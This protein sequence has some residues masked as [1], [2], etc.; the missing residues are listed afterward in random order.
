MLLTNSQ[1]LLGHSFRSIVISIKRTR[2]AKEPVPEK[3]TKWTETAADRKK[4]F[5][6][7][8]GQAFVRIGGS[9]LSHKEQLDEK[10]FA[11]SNSGPVTVFVLMKNLTEGQTCSRGALESCTRLQC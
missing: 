5:G 7:F 10:T 2:A 6:H 9:L 4:R 8:P 1:Q 3:S 11:A